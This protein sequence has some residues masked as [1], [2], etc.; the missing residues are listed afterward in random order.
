VQAADLL[1]IL[2]RQK[3]RNHRADGADRRRVWAAVEQR[4][5]SHARRRAF[6]GQHHLTAGSRGL[7]D[8]HV[9]LAEQEKAAALFALA[10]QRLAGR[11]PLLDRALHDGADLVR[12]QACEQ[13]NL[14]EYG[15][16]IGNAQ[17]DLRY[18]T[19]PHVRSM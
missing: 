11:K 3:K 5:L 15:N 18:L 2:F 8:L 16:S 6:D 19:L 13:R 9:A 4:H 17:R 12:A 1:K 10:A 7:V 14:A